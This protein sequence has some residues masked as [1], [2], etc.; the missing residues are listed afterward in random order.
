M[1]L[2]FLYT[3]SLLLCLTTF[4]SSNE[5]AGHC[6]PICKEAAGA[7][8]T[9]CPYGKKAPSEASV[10]EAADAPSSISASLPILRLLSI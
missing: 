5:R 3:L 9:P 6:T 1:K 4:A 2:K 7:A 10:S 8:E